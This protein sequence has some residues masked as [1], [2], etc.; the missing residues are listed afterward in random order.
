MNLFIAHIEVNK[1]LLS[2]E[3]SHHM[4]RVLRMKVGDFVFVTDGKGSIYKGRIQSLT[5]KMAVVGD[6][7]KLENT[8]K[9]NYQ[10]QMIV[11]PTKQ[12]DRVEFFLEKSVEIGLDEFCPIITSNSERRKINHERL[13]RI[14]ISAMKQS[15]KAELPVVYELQSFDAFLKKNQIQKDQKFIA[16]CHEDIKQYNITEVIKP[17]QSYQFLI[18]PEGD[19]S[20]DEVQIAMQ[21]GFTPISLGSQRMRTE[22]AALSCVAFTHF[23]H[24]K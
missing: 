16:H 24:L 13:E 8:Q 4:S 2:P 5:G 10:L 7:E 11:A 14:A 22:T 3:E 12:I 21:H 6:L 19:F 1:A 18:G 23:L 20:K 15:L 9:R 17:E